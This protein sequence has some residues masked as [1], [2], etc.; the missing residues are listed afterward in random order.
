[1]FP[2]ADP[3]D[4]VALGWGDAETVLALGGQVAGTSDW[5]GFGGDGVGPWAADRV[6]RTPE[7]LGT[8]EISYE[9]VA[10]LAPGVIL[11]T[12]QSNDAARQR[13]L[14][15][16]APAVGPPPGL[17]IQ[18]GTSWQD[19]VRLV[20]AGQHHTGAVR[21]A[22]TEQQQGS[23][24]R[25][26]ELADSTAVPRNAGTAQVNR[27]LTTLGRALPGGSTSWAVA[28]R[29]LPGDDPGRHRLPG[30]RAGPSPES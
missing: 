13:E 23:N 14:T 30:H 27:M 24:P 22:R 21:R 18:H 28:A 6:T 10:A 4:V 11:D 19:Q 8:P 5:L 16:I 15:K 17:E 20:A 2:P 25:A 12:R 26:R 7:Q 1:M 29:P 3:Q 9:A